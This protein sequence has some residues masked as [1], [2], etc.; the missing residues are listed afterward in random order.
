[1]S[2]NNISILLVE[3]HRQLAQTIVEF[4]EETGA[5]VDYAGDGRLARALV[6]EH[7]YDLS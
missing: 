3:D 2:L 5:L 1:M 4:L 6:S 7:D